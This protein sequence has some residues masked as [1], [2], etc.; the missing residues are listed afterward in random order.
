[1]KKIVWLI[2]LLCGLEM[3]AAERSV[4]QAQALA[5]QFA[6]DRSAMCPLRGGTKVAP[7]M[8]LAHTRKKVNKEEAAF[9]VFNNDDNRGFVV[10]SAD[11]RAVDV[12][13]YAEEGQFDAEHINPNLRFW[14][15][16]LQEE[17]SQAN[18][19]NAVDNVAP[20]KATT[21]IGP[22]LKNTAGKEITWYQEA[23]YSNLCPIDRLDNTRCL[24]G[25]VA[26]AAA[27]VMYK[28]RY[29][30]KGTGSKTYT[31]YNGNYRSQQETLTANFGATTYDWDNMLPSY[32]G[33]RY[34]DAQATA[35]ATLMYQL[36]VASEMEYGGDGAG[37]S[38]TLTDLMALGLTKYFGYKVSKFVT[39]YSRREYEE[40]GDCAFSP[41]EFRVSA[42]TL[43]N[44]F[45]E[46]L[47]AGRPIIMGGEDTDGGHEFVCDGRDSRGY[48]HINWGWEGDGNCY[49]QLTSLKPNGYSYNF[50]GNLDA[51]IGL[52]PAVIDS[53][54]VTSI[55]LDASAITLKINEKRTVTATVL[56][57][58]ATDTYYTWSSGNNNV[59]TVSN[60]G[61]IKGIGQG[62]TSITATTRDG[63][64]KAS[65]AV[66]VTNEV[67]VADYFTLVTDVADL[68]AG[69]EILIVGTA[70]SVHYA[71]TSQLTTT[72]SAGYLSVENV[73]ITDY[74]VTLDETSD[75]AVFTLG[76]KAGAWTLTHKNGQLGAVKLR[77]LGWNA[78]ADTWTIAINSGIATI[79]S[80]TT[81][82]GRLL[83]NYN[84][85]NPRFCNY[86]AGT[87]TSDAMVLPQIYS[88][89]TSQPT[90][91]VPVT[92]ISLGQ[93]SAQMVVGDQIPLYYTVHPVTATNQ[94]VTWSSSRPEVASVS[95]T[96][97]VNALQAGTTTIT[98][99]TSDGA[100][101]A[102]CQITVTATV[103]PTKDTIFVTA[104][105]AKA[106][107]MT[108]STGQL[109]EQF[110]GVR[111]Y[112]TVPNST[113][114]LGFWIADAPGD[115]Q[116]FQG[117]NCQMPSGVV[118]LKEGQYVCVYGYIM[119][120]NNGKMQIKD[121]V[122]ELL[123][124][125]SAME[126]TT[127]PHIYNKLIHRGQLYLYRN[128]AWWNAQGLPVGN[129]LP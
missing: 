16:R 96:G 19:S 75:V 6:N 53:V 15:N 82:Y 44:Y 94:N 90:G 35:V 112:V 71:A 1:M 4:E 74:T 63:K 57:A 18:D 101:Q 39:M 88:R 49:C 26:T 22:L 8:R 98:I 66:T 68:A 56:P 60:T 54:H 108:L 5:M 83:L 72:A 33:V 11:S 43:T 119:N 113:A 59:A 20:R 32:E 70:K 97:V 102:T 10:V 62:K 28:W 31:W 47:E 76:G 114:Y 51:I 85:G 111:G 36:G 121:G 128:N 127:I 48:F 50:S 27:Q 21:Q 122:V 58:D 13:L 77:K 3:F 41:T 67:A 2:G 117:F 30:A 95:E 45:N 93:A 37:G 84:N 129:P 14:L 12:P 34:T 65:V 7:A 38:G 92:G 109:T 25:C 115:E 55:T 86:G 87:P 120:Y 24:T 123:D 9:Y 64:K 73:A 107:G 89:K 79:N 118:V 17:I 46:D 78:D 91:V 80:A 40:Y 100:Y 69:D 105:E 52:Q 110:Y 23:P 116:T 103:V 106:I 61:V 124:T 81:S 29:P 104:S 99:T 126:T 42:T 125:P